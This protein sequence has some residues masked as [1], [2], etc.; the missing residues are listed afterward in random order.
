MAAAAVF[1]CVGSDMGAPGLLVHATEFDDVVIKE[2]EYSQPA[3][4]LPVD[5]LADL[6]EQRWQRVTAAKLNGTFSVL[7]ACLYAM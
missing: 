1:K 7:R 6:T 3:S 4:G 5:T 2:K